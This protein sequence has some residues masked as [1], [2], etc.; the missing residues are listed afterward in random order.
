MTE[1]PLHLFEA[2]GIELEYMIV[3]TANLDV[4]PLAPELFRSV[5][6]E[7]EGDVER[8]LITWSNE[9]MAHVIEY[10][11]T[12]PA[13]TLE[14]LSDAFHANVRETLDIL[15]AW[16]VR[17][18]PGAMHPWM[19][20]VREAILWPHGYNEVYRAFDRIFG[21]KGHGW[22]NLQSLHINLPFGSDD[23]FGRLHA[24]IRLLLPLMP[25][26]AASSPIYDGRIQDALDCR[27]EAYRHNS[28][29]VPSVAGHIIPEQAYSHRVY[30]DEILEPMYRD[31]A[32]LDPEGI[33]HDEWLNA[34]G[35]IARFC[36]GSI[37]VRVLDVQECPAAD[38][39]VGYLIT[40][41]LQALVEER[42]SPYAA[43]QAWEI[44]PLEAI[45]LKTIRE[46]EGA[47]I[48]DV[49][50]LDVL[51]VSGRSMTAG[52]AWR[53]LYEMISAGLSATDQDIM[54]PV[55]VILSEGSLAS[56]IK[57]AVGHEPSKGRLSAVYGSLCDCLEANEP[58]HAS[59][60]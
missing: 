40:K 8:G 43:Q 20:P 34:R 53:R 32:A 28:I 56:R 39:A 59:Q 51:G 11:T 44:G 22:A 45:L 26:L 17:L 31:I 7:G 47:Q 21:C 2:L 38:I 3:D 36:R 5:A 48:E 19:D 1:E 46:A 35:A 24:A 6:G 29:R 50:Y 54:R 57:A 30:E 60:V 55:E 41:A 16:G 33:L 12:E 52:E 13:K 23:E 10:K 15:R 49:D 9:L 14:G 25:A 4:R 42:H 37:E 27:M 18:M 58:F